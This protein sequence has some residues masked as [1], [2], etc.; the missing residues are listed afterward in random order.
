M[1]R[2]LFVAFLA[3]T[4]IVLTDVSTGAADQPLGKLFIK[5]AKAKVDGQDF[6]DQELEDSVKDLKKRANK[7]LLVEDESQADF[8]LVVVKRETKAGQPSLMK[9]KTPRNVNDLHATISIKENEGWK[10]GVQLSTN[11]CCQF[12]TDAASKIMSEAEKWAKLQEK[13]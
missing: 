9:H 12:W 8:L 11:G 10:P 13:R 3:C 5:A 7:F 4:L 1:K 6:A 2:R